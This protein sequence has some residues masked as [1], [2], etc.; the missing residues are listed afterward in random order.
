MLFHAMVEY[1]VDRDEDIAAQR[2]HN[3]SI[4]D[5][6]KSSV[7]GIIAQYLPISFLFEMLLKIFEYL[8]IEFPMKFLT[9]YWNDLFILC[10]NLSFS[11]H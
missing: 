11:I 10:V 5:T 4:I 7:G 2:R 6:S 3:E 9:F 8:N 1:E